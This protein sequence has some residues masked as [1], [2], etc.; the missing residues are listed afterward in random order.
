MVDM[1]LFPSSFFSVTKVDED[2]QREYDAVL[3]TGLFEVALFG[4]DQW[5]NDG[6]LVVKNAPNE[7]H[8]AVYRGWMMKPGQYERFY[9][10]LLENNIKLVT[11]PAEYERMHIFPNI[12]E[13][14][15]EDTAKMEKTNEYR[16]FYINH[17]PATI[18]KNSGQ[19]NYKPWPPKE[20]I[21]KYRNLE[22]K[23]YTVDLTELEDGTWRIL[24]AGDGGVS[25]LSEEQDYEQYFRALYQ[26]FK[27][28]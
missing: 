15:K 27:D 17:E 8:L 12:Y 28:V 20:L 5:F 23:Y 16:I 14:L 19:G 4:Y 26:C 13:R 11:E 10:L 6:K 3:F 1:I 22:S 18:S 24:E 2:L 7:L 25:G 21:D 9:H